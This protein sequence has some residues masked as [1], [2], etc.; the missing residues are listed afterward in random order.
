[1]ICLKKR[2]KRRNQ[3][4]PKVDGSQQVASHFCIHHPQNE[5]YN[6][7]TISVFLLFVQ[8]SYLSLSTKSDSCYVEDRRWAGLSTC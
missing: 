3:G 5:G 4:Q 2:R 1:M 8:D 6:E 7:V